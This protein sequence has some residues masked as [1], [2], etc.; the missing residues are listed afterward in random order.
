MIET[1]AKQKECDFVLLANVSHKKGG[2][3]FGS[4]GKALGSVVSQTGGGNWGN[5]AANN[6][7][8]VAA[9]T[10]VAATISQNVKS[11]DE[12]TL[13][14]LLKQP[15]GATALTQKFTAKAKSDGDDIISKVVEQAAEAIVSKAG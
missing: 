5:T 6:V 8:R 14:I 2:G 3:G 11:K 7:G 1:E 4:F 12:I 15:G 10:I 9:N 13:E